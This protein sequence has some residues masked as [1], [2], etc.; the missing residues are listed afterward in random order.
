MGLSLRAFLY[1]SAAA[2][3]F[4]QLDSNSITVSA[5][6]NASLQADQ[7][8]FAVSINTDLT[9]G[10]GEVLAAV[11]PAGLTQANFVGVSSPQASFIFEPTPGEGPLPQPL[12][13]QRLQWV[14]GAPVPIAKTKDMVSALTN[15][16]RS[17]A[18]VPNGPRLS[19]SVQGTQVSP[20]LQ[21][22]QTCAVSDLI[23]DARTQA[24]KLAS[25]AGLNLGSVLALA[26]ATAT[27]SLGPGVYL[28]VP[29]GALI[30]AGP[31]GL[32]LAAPCSI[33][34]KFALR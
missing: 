13:Q 33:T 5:S 34:V 30:S 22:S 31:F 26:S 21:Q 23:S 4:A 10:L 3:A 25:A 15:L 11:E 6:R 9:A 24:Q 19:F 18:Q 16:Q 7:V 8:V 32:P 29:V 14:F 28:G 1:L 20:Q 17:L 27:T 2:C 12:P